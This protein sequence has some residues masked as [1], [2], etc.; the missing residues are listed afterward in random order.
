[1]R[2]PPAGGHGRRKRSLNFGARRL[3]RVQHRLQLATGVS[4]NRGGR[5]PFASAIS[6]PVSKNRRSTASE[7]G[8]GLSR[9]QHRLRRGAS[10]G[11][12]VAVSVR[13]SDGG[14][15]HDRQPRREMC[16]YRPGP[17]A[18]P[19]NP[20]VA[21]PTSTRL[22]QSRASPSAA[23]FGG[24]DSFSLAARRSREDGEVWTR[25]I[26]RAPA[27]MVPRPRPLAANDSSALLDGCRPSGSPR[28][29]PAPEG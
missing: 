10:P 28:A 5:F 29:R 24:R 25:P 15:G 11:P 17:A 21:T 8:H 19:P 1:M 4:K 16:A 6:R 2:G 9:R 26:T 27:K 7:S 13:D 22:D 23:R 3:R 12:I 18:R 14:Q 20:A